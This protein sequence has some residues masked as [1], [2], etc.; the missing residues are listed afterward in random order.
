MPRVKHGGGLV[1][2]WGC[3]AF[4]GTRN[5]QH[6]QDERDS[7][8]YQDILREKSPP[9]LGFKRSPGSSVASGI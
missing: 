5:P 6:V 1:M 7:F 3:F 8:R 9:G 4:S 2:L